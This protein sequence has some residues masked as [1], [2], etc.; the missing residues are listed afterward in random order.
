[1]PPISPHSTGS[2]PVLHL[3]RSGP[4]RPLLMDARH[5]AARGDSNVPY[6]GG[7]VLL[8]IGCM[9]LRLTFIRF[10]MTPKYRMPT[11]PTVLVQG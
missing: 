7:V 5:I 2:M 1:M 9:G 11:V 8:E 3:Q 4:A 10:R 6:I